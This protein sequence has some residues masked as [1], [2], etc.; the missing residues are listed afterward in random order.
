MFEVFE[1]WK[2]LDIPKALCA[3]AYAL[4]ALKVSLSKFLVRNG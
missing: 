1:T 3:K 4:E 2:T